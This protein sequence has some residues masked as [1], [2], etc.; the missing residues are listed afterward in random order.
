MKKN[1]KILIILMAVTI[2]GGSIGYY[3]VYYR[4]NHL[5]PDSRATYYEIFAKEEILDGT[6]DSAAILVQKLNKRLKKYHQTFEKMADSTDEYKLKAL[7][8]MN[9]VHMAGIYGERGLKENSLKEILWSGNNMQCGTYTT[10]LAMLLDKSGYQF[11]TISIG[12]GAHGY[13]EI[14]WDN[15]WQ[16]LD[17]TINIWIDKNTDEI[18]NKSPRQ[19]RKFFLKAEDQFN[20]EANQ[21][22][23][24]VINVY[25]MMTK[26]GE[27]YTPKIDQYNYIDLEQYQY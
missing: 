2:L 11:R 17:P 24:R 16:V 3:L 5:D 22:I 23:L 15:H 7:F 14:F 21:N 18:L 13:V 6:E 20:N 19:I 10:L 9:F 27:G 25:D 4:N 12:G 26:L 8:Y 1:T